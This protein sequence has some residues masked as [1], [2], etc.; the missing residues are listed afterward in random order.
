MLNEK[1]IQELKTIREMNERLADLERRL[2]ERQVELTNPDTLSVSEI[3]QLLE[4]VGAG[5]FRFRL[6][7]R[8]DQL[9]KYPAGV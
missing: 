2:Y 4:I 7:H 6:R 9:T 8:L 1:T 3:E 5:M